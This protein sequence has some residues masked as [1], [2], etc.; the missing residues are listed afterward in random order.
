MSI[1]VIVILIYHLYKPM[2][3]GPFPITVVLNGL[4]D[5]GVYETLFYI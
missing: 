4:I 5:K 2:K 1:I 3:G